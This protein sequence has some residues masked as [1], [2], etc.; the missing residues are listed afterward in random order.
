MRFRDIPRYSMNLVGSDDLRQRGILAMEM[1]DSVRDDPRRLQPHFHDFFQMYWLEG[2]TGVMID[3]EE[4]SISGTHVVFLYPGQV[5]TLRP[6]DLSGTTVS[7]TQAFFDGRTPPPSRLLGFPFFLPDGT[8]S[9]FAVPP[10][11]VP[12]IRGLFKALVAE[13]SRALP[14]AEEMLRATLWLLLLKLARLSPQYGDR[15]AAGRARA[16]VRQFSLAV[17]ESFREEHSLGFYA[18]RLG[19]T[20][21]HL[22]DTVREQTGASAGEMVRLRRLLD[23]KRLLLHSDLSIAEIGYQIGFKEPS[24]FARF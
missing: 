10:E 2:S 23:A 13:Y 3:F 24:Y 14:D 1:M 18:K 17:E 20:A 8:A 21:N 16:L 4:F 9:S 11:V 12:E 15:Q 19:V 22:N 5:H 7:F 6:G